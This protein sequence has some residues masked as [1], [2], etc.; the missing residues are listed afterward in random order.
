MSE[1]GSHCLLSP[2]RWPHQWRQTSW[3]LLA[4]PSQ[5]MQIR[6]RQ[7]VLV[8]ALSLHWIQARAPFALCKQTFV[9]RR[10][11][12]RARHLPVKLF[13]DGG[14]N[15]DDS[16]SMK[17]TQTWK[18]RLVKRL[19]LC[20]SQQPKLYQHH[21]F[22]RLS[23]IVN[24]APLDDESKALSTAY[25]IFCRVIWQHLLAYRSCVA[26]A[27]TTITH[28]IN[29]FCWPNIWMKSHPK[30]CTVFE[31]KASSWNLLPK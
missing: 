5:I 11:Q 28:G 9:S 1:A 4:A 24:S 21:T 18:I 22:E 17:A 13:S 14:G 10:P 8:T 2:S 25:N 27:P 19:K 3:A 15:K 7:A 29:W 23:S 16:L 26:M 6:H 12:V 30:R 31:L 20:P